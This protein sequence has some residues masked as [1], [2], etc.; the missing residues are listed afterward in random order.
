MAEHDRGNGTGNDHARWRAELAADLAALVDRYGGARFGARVPGRP[1]TDVDRART[2]R[3]AAYTASLA[4]ELLRDLEAEQVDR[5]AANGASYDEIGQQFHLGRED[6]RRRWP[7]AAT[8][9]RERRWMVLHRDRYLAVLSAMLGMRDRLVRGRSGAAR[10]PGAPPSPALARALVEMQAMA[11]RLA[12]PELAVAELLVTVPP[13][14]SWCAGTG[15][16]PDEPEI[17]AAV[18]RVRLALNDLR[19]ASL[20]EV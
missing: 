7:R 4:R 19:D 11:D 6:A 16:H 15:P 9:M 8:V 17:A 10:E 3:A 5:A 14:T 12:D 13:V 18:S 1:A 20:A 2:H